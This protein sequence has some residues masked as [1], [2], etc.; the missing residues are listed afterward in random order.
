MIIERTLVRKAASATSTDSKVHSYSS[1]QIKRV[2]HALRS[3]VSLD[4][5]TVWKI[6][7]QIEINNWQSFCPPVTIRLAS[8]YVGCECKLI[9][10]SRHFTSTLFHTKTDPWGVFSLFLELCIFC[11]KLYVVFS[12]F[13]KD[14]KNF[15]VNRIKKHIFP[16]LIA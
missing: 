7:L 14:V 1:C 8:R 16:E 11:P 2:H 5:T 15:S 9:A 12:G 3:R 4:I 13:S 10:S 6:L